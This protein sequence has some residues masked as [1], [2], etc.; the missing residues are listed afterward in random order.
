MQ[1]NNWSNRN[2]VR[3][4]LLTRAW[5]DWLGRVPWQDFITLTF[6]PKKVFPVGRDRASSEAFR[7]LSHAEYA[8]RRPLAWAYS[9]ERG[10]SGHWHVHALVA[11][12]T[13][14]NWSRLSQVWKRHN[15]IVDVRPVYDGRGVTLYT[16]KAGADAEVVIADTVT[17]ARFPALADRTPLDLWPPDGD[18][19]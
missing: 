4:T 16:T 5:G 3:G 6:D 13:G 15:G 8:E 14:V 17:L 18:A 12:S 10:R 19:R 9:T 2:R 1:H 11:G 7:W